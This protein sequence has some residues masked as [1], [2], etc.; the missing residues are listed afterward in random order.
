[1]RR[2]GDGGRIAPGVGQQRPH[3]P[4][5]PPYAYTEHGGSEHGGSEHGGYGRRVAGR[6]PAVG[7]RRGNDGCVFVILRKQTM[8]TPFSLRLKFFFKC[9]SV[10]FRIARPGLRIL[11]V[12]SYEFLFFLPLQ[13]Q[14]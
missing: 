2:H 4:E 9:F 5:F 13:K 3:V 6:A 12:L 10:D 14:Y 7:A 8:V 11:S 1:M